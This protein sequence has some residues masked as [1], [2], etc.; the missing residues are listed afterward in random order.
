[1]IFRVLKLVCLLIL[2][3]LNLGGSTDPNFELIL[4]IRLVI[5]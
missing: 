2:L 3:I 1:M 5:S 4:L